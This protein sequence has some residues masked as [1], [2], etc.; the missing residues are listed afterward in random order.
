[1]TYSR[2]ELALRCLKS[3]VEQSYPD[4]EIVLVI[5]PSGDGT[6]EAIGQNFPQIKVIRT[7]KNIGF[8]PALNIAIA[9]T[10]GDYIM[11]VDDDAYFLDDKAIVHLV[12]EFQREP[13]L[14]AVTCNLEGPHETPIDADR[15]IEAFT[16]GFTMVPRRVFTEGVGYYPDI[17]FR[18]A[19]ETYLC[20][21]LWEL[22]RPVKRLHNVRMYH[23]RATQGRSDR[24]WKFHSLR[25]Q[26]LC[27][28]MR[29][30]WYILP[31][32]L[33]SKGV[34]GLFQYI[35]WGQSSIWILAWLSALLHLP[36]ALRQRRPISWRTQVLLWRLRNGKNSQRCKP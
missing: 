20:T 13:K 8:F 35:R 16:T 5:N 12:A 21:W 34:K 3:C 23:E 33:A 19:G 18:S 11:T 31:F 27:A 2:R 9:N 22:G 29:D 32:S 25:S 6:E 30:P 4:L 17:F 10:A 28:I 26:L 1:M 14:G 15:Y 7:H 24:D 36:A